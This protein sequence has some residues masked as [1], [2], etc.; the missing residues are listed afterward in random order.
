MAWFPVSRQRFNAL[1]YPQ[2]LVYCV[3]MSRINYGEAAIQLGCVC[4][5]GQCVMTK[6]MLAGATGVSQKTISRSLKRLGFSVE[7]VVSREVNGGRVL[8]V[9]VPIMMRRDV[10]TPGQTPVQTSR[11]SKPVG[12]AGVAG[13]GEKVVS[14]PLS[15]PASPLVLEK[16]YNKTAIG[17]AL[18]TGTSPTPGLRA[19]VVALESLYTSEEIL[20]AVKK[21]VL[22]EGPRTSV[23]G[24]VRTVVSRVLKENKKD[25][26]LP[27]RKKPAPL[28]APV[29]PAVTSAGIAQFKE[30]LKNAVTKK[31]VTE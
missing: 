29:A 26:N 24:W 11:D 17:V 20:Q 8:R 21:Q 28:P 23:P 14:P 16:R 1:D 25:A 7:T 18:A 27:E 10:Q 22:V 5:D 4:L 30:A 19:E 2:N 31:N 9:T 3:V 12:A 13:D 15:I 6:A